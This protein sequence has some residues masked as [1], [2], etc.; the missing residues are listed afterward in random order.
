M[1]AKKKTRIKWGNVALV[2]V[3][4]LA[5]GVGAFFF[6][7]PN[8]EEGVFLLPEPPPAGEYVMIDFH[9]PRLSEDGWDTESR[10]IELADQSVMIHAVISGVAAGPYRTAM[11][12]PS[13]PAGLAV[14][15]IEFAEAAARVDIGFSETFNGISA[16]QRINLIGSLVYTLT[17]LDFVSDLRFFVGEDRENPLFADSDPL[18]RRGNTSL[19]AEVPPPTPRLITLYFP[20]EQMLWLRAEE[21]SI[22]VDALIGGAYVFAVEALFAGPSIAGLS[23]SFPA[24][25]SFNSV[26]QFDNVV[27]VDFTSD[28]VNSMTGGS[29][30]E[31]W[32]I[33]SLVNTLT[34]LSGVQ[35][36]QIL[37]DGQAVAADDARFHMDLSSPIERNEDLIED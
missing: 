29:S 27:F 30:A 28:F 1:P 15:S 37:V 23:P 2:A 21:R 11:L 34:G 13:F 22:A 3:I 20:D 32:M 10:Q 25:A 35:S 7:A 17:E 16:S 31:F 8:E 26:Q 14:L 12:A 19:L 5:V 33:Y 24:N 9:F 36:V 18:R 4:A 6:F